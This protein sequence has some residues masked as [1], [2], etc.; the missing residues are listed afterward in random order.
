MKVLK[1]KKEKDLISVVVPV[2][3]VE[4]YLDDC[5]N[6][7]REQTYQNLEIILVDDGSTDSCSKM[8]DDYAQ[9][10]SRIQVIHQPNRGLSGARNSGLC[11]SKGK[12][13][14]F[15][16]S[17]D[18]IAS[19]MIEVL[20]D[21]IT[22]N[23]CQVSCCKY[24]AFV[25]DEMMALRNTGVGDYSTH[26]KNNISALSCIY[27]SKVKKIEFVVWNKLYLRSLFVENEILYPEKKLNEDMFTTYKLLYFSKQTAIID[28]EL[29]FYRKRPGSIMNQ[30]LTMKRL[31]ALEGH[32][33]CMHFYYDHQEYQLLGFEL[34]AFLNDCKYLMSLSNSV[35]ENDIKKEIKQTI[36]TKAIQGKNLYFKYCKYSL[37]M[38]LYYIIK[39]N[40]IVWSISYE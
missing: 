30:S 36:K 25:D 29:Y 7:V 28:Q 11:E 9:I 22:K 24:R 26:I 5:V 13:I 12:Y 21:A 18:I 34:N 17:D 3:K 40:V 15:I 23:E 32:E 14:I 1:L 19:N 37:F 6:S 35:E 31:D 39:F 20:Y 8:C 4:H 10:D 38:K 33:S 27:H 16:D 2:Y